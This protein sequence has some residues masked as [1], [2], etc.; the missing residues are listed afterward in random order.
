[1]DNILLIILLILLIFFLVN[2]FS[3][4]NEYF[5]NN[6]IIFYKKNNLFNKLK[7]DEDNYFK[8][9]FE[10]DFKVRNVKNSEEYIS[11]LENSIIEPDNDIIEKIKRYVIKIKKKINEHKINSDNYQYINLEKL[12]N[13]QWKFGFIGDNN[14]EN[15]L[16]HTRN[17]IIILNKNKINYNS[18][19]KNMR[20]LIHEQI[21]VY[22]KLYPL[23]LNNYLN[24]KNFQKVKKRTKYDNIRA[25]PDL[26]N[27]IYKDKDNNIYKAIYNSNP[28]SVEDI[29]YYPYNEQFY[30]HPYERMAIEFESILDN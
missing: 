3:N 11:I 20:T 23:D 1:M 4:K 19:S 13:I 26:D 22:Q 30:E 12:N 16:P 8:S 18:D 14:Y 17:D 2:N 10:T 24:N 29:K 25:N 5:S 27:Y 28:I 6:D 21:H 7:K 9:F 15:G